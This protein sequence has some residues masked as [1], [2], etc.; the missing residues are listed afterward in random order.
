MKIYFVAILLLCLS[1]QVQAAFPVVYKTHMA[2]DTASMRTAP[3]LRKHKTLFVKYS[4]YGFLVTCASILVVTALTLFGQF[5]YGDAWL[6]F[7]AIMAAV[8]AVLA[9]IGI[10]RGEGP[11]GRI[12]LFLSVFFLLLVLLFL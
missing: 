1:Y 5:D 11:Y 12:M 4:A 7:A 9:I 8:S 2:A 3:K 6:S 10:I